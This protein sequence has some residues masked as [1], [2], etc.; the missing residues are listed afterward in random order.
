MAE[1]C[2]EIFNEMANHFDS[3]AAG[4]WTTTIQFNISG[5]KGGDFVL[6]IEGGNLSVSEGSTDGAK[7]TIE[8]SDETW[9]GIVDGSTNPMTAFTLGQLK[10]KGDMGAVMKLQ[11][12]IKK[13]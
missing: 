2:K 11:N 9:M 3:A 13:G 10:I 7:A 1:N 5:D 6:N 8:T 4:D 12:M